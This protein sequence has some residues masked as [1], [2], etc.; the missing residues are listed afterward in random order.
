MPDDAATSVERAPT[1]PERSPPLIKQ[2][3]PKGP[4]APPDTLVPPGAYPPGAYPPQGQPPMSEPHP[5][6]LPPA[7]PPPGY[8]PSGYP[9]PGS[10][11]PGYVLSDNSPPGYGPP[12]YGPPGYTP[13]SHAYTVRP[14]RVDVLGR[15][16]AEWW[17]RFLAYLID[18]VVLAVPGVIILS[19]TANTT[20]TSTGTT[21]SL[22]TGT[23]VGVGLGFIVALGYFSF[24]DGSRRGQTLGKLALNISV[25]DVTNGGPIGAGR[26]LARRFIFFATYLGFAVLFLVNALSPLW[27]PR[28]QAW[29]DHAVRSCV[30]VLR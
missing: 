2:P 4:T 11:P 10:A 8:L 14:G 25:C 13:P 15:P 21:V 17:Q 18:A 16:M 20:N 23:W 30:V 29:H 5:G 27:D 7:Y 9:P 6:Y 12:G 28:R 24:L 3:K 26:A 19:L 22:T 1:E